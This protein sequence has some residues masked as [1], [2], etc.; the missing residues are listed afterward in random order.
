MEAGRHTLHTREGEVATR[1]VSETGGRG[2]LDRATSKSG[3]GETKPSLKT[4]E[5]LAFL[6]AVVGVLIASAID[7]GIDGRLP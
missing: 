5:L 6:A 3:Y 2:L 4:T 7:D 1:D